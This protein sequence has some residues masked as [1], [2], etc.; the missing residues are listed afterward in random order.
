MTRWYYRGGH[1]GYDVYD[2]HVISGGPY[3]FFPA[4]QRARHARY[5]REDCAYRAHRARSD[6][7]GH[8]SVR[9]PLA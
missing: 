8:Q 5:V 2:G 6:R 1:V 3:S 4:G 9:I 7:M